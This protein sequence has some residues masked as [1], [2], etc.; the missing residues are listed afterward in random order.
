M[1]GLTKTLIIIFDNTDSFEGEVECNIPGKIM[2]DNKIFT[3]TSKGIYLPLLP[4]CLLNAKQ[5]VEL[6]QGKFTPDLWIDS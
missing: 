4:H 6:S 3:K 2:F 5:V 1:A